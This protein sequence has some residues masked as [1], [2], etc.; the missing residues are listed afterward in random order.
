MSTGKVGSEQVPEMCDPS[1]YREG[2]IWAS[3]GKVEIRASTGK[4]GLGRVSEM[5]D[6]GEY[7]KCGIRR[8][9]EKSSG[10]YWK[11]GIRASAEKVEI[12]A[13]TRKGGIRASTENVGSEQVPKMWDPSKYGKGGIR[14]STGKGM[15]QT[16]C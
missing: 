16:R 3:T 5:W 7:R 15:I 2:G 6:L 14:A 9:P 8:V 10:E 11:D 12:R 13:S 1:E 4:V